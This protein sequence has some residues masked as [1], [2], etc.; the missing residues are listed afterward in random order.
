MH[1]NRRPTQD[2]ESVA[3]KITFD[4]AARVERLE[5]ANRTLL[6]LLADYLGKNVDEI[7]AKYREYYEQ[8]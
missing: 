4:L 8:G 6:H 2:N 5:K 7:A 1:M 3:A